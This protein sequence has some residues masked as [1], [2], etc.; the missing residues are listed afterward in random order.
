MGDEQNSLLIKEKEIPAVT[1]SSKPSSLDEIK[2]QG[3]R[4]ERQALIQ[5]PA[6][7]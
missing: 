4:I 6:W 5:H 1:S 3:K 2:G 7:G